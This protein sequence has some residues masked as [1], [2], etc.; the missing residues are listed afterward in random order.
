MSLVG[1]LGTLDLMAPWRSFLMML[2]S[3]YFF[4]ELI[5]PPFLAVLFCC[6]YS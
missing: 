6:G 2:K 1:M 3:S 5:S 4:V